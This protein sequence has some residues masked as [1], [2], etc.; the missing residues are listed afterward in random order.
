MNTPAFKDTYNN[1]SFFL[2]GNVVSPN[3]LGSE[4]FEILKKHFGVLTA[5]NAMKPLFLQGEK[6]LFSFETADTLVNAALEAGLKVHGHTLSWHQQSPEW[7]NCEGVSRNEAIENLVTHAKTVAG[8][9]SGRVI[10]WD[11][12]NEAIMDG[13]PNADDWRASLRETPWLKAIGP[14]YVET[15]FKAA[16]EAD[17]AAKLYYNDYNMDYQDKALAVCNMVKE[18]NEKNPDILGRPL[19]DGIGMQGHYRLNTS[20]ENVAASIK[21]FSSLGVE[22]SI[23][24]LDVLAGEDSV[25]SELQAVQ[26][27]IVYA[28]LFALFREH[29]DKIAR[30]TI[31]GLDD[32]S[33]WRAKQNPLLFNGHLQPKPAFFAAMDPAAFLAEKGNIS[34]G[35]KTLEADALYGTPGLDENDPVWQTASAIPV[36]QYLM[37]WQGAHGTAKVLWDENNLYVKIFVENAE[38][39]KANPATAEQDSVEIFIDEGSHKARTI[40]TDDGAFRINYSNACSFSRAELAEGFESAAF[41]SGNSYTVVAKI[42]FRTVTPEE[43]TAIGFD[44]QINGA[45]PQGIR[46]SVAVWNDTSG[47]SWQSPLGYGILHLAGRT[48]GFK[49]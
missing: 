40:E 48:S 30:V 12:L 35:G 10:S 47:N 19:I 42:P 5:E 38:M 41:V 23:T 36:N 20:M 11:V 32:H 13:P 45:S 7:M 21:R 39:N 49:Q 28:R 27:G 18:I 22:V 29:S 1:D 33:S 26:Q 2:A 46:Q 9:F 17:P 24:E 4:R 14:E 37:A 3:D 31:W 6:G 25:L 8:H 44:L 34:V 15:V 43:G 16:R